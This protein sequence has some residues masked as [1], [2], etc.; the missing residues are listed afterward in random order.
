[1]KYLKYAKYLFLHRW[2]V[3]LECFRHGLIWRGL[4]HDWH[5]HLPSEWFPYMEHFHGKEK[6]Y[7]REWEK[8]KGYYKPTDTGDPAFDLAWLRHAHKADHH[9][10]WWTQPEDSGGVKVLEMSPRARLEMVCDWCGASRAQGHGGWSGVEEW[11]AK[12]GGRMM[13]GEGTRD[14]VEHF[15][16][17]KTDGLEA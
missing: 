4:I 1:M 17:R 8:N 15:L 16:S 2:F 13:L 5:K 7:L 10:Q 9:W 6:K 3:M 14:W 11:Y 12:N